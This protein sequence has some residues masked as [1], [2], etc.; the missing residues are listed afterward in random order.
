[1]TSTAP[2]AIRLRNRV[3]TFLLYAIVCVLIALA[4]LKISSIVE[5]HWGRDA[6]FKWGGLT[7]FTLILF[8]FFIGA[9][10]RYL[11]SRRFWVVTAILLVGHLG[12]FALVLTHVDGWRELWFIFLEYPIFVF[13]RETFI[14]PC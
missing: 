2:R 10:E 13:L 14:T 12:V 1:M 4:F 9:S 8:L 6:L 3:R 5:D 11:H 7:L